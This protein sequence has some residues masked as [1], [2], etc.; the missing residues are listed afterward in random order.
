M[1]RINYTKWSFPEQCNQLK[2]PDAVSPVQDARKQ[3]LGKQGVL[4]V[5]HDLT[6]MVLRVAFEIMDFSKS[7]T[8]TF[9]F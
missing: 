1:F 6:E 7:C 2:P 8:N 3:Q 5:M 9:N 4:L